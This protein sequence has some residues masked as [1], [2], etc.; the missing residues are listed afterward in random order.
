MDTPHDI[1]TRQQVYLE[2]LKAG[3]ERDWRRGVAPTLR[4]SARAMLTALDVENMQDLSK[5]ELN[6]MLARL[7]DAH[8]RIATEGMLEFSDNLQPLAGFSSGLEVASLSELIV[9]TGILFNAPTAAIAYQYAI[10]SPVQATGQLLDDFIGS[11]P[12]VDVKRIQGVISTGWAQNKPLMQM[13]RETVGTRKNGYADG[14]LGVSERNAGAIIHTATQHTANAARM[15]VFEDN[16][17]IIKG[18]TWISTLDRRTTPQCRSLDGMVFNAGKGPMP[19]LH[20]RCRSTTVA[21]L[22]KKY[23]F[24]D[25]GATRASAGASGGKTVSADETYYSW[26]TKQPARF[27]DIAIG[28]VRGNLLRNG[29]LTSER[30]ASLNLGRD[31]QPLTLKEMKV[32]EP[33]AFKRAGILR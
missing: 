7:S 23:D 15:K 28:P 6:T 16:N 21:K 9:D 18:Y 2:R 22:D 30:F 13:V 20:I 11:W 26:L 33:E 24:L 8:V 17:D 31:F 1:A 32:L 4:E 14:A 19:P 12:E 3:F 10:T 5:A 27:Q 25:D 29:G